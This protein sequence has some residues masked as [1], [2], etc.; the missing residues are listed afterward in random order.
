MLARCVLAAAFLVAA[1]PATASAANK[2]FRG[3]TAQS[4]AVRLVVNES[5]RVQGGIRIR[6]RVSARGSRTFDAANR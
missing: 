1:L 5:G 6:I 3:E 4:R 2:R